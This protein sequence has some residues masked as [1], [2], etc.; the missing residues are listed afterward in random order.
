MFDLHQAQ[1]L[2]DQLARAH[3]AIG[4]L[5]PALGA[6]AIISVIAAFLSLWLMQ[7]MTVLAGLRGTMSLLRLAQR[8]SLAWLALS[9][10]L[11]AA[12]PYLPYGQDLIN[13]CI[14]ASIFVLLAA[15]AV[16]VH[17]NPPKI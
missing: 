15:S 16:L 4:K 3:G 6:R 7:S 10:M 14:T 9:M 1:A 2:A 8:C 13:L 11:N 5:V 17:I 12:S